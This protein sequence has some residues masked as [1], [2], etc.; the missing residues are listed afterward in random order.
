MGLQQ[1]DQLRERLIPQT[2]VFGLGE[3][4]GNALRI[5]NRCVEERSHTLRNLVAVL[6]NGRDTGE[7]VPEIHSHRR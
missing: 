7:G 1:L 3:D 6:G 2:N 5:H 4:V